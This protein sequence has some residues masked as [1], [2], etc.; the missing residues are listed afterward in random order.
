MYTK[1]L[2]TLYNKFET[3]F[4]HSMDRIKKFQKTFLNI[5]GI[6]KENIIKIPVK[7]GKTLREFYE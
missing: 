1:F 4:K 6:F 7:C 2:P 3:I 5:M